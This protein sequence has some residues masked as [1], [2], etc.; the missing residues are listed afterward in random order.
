M[1]D[2]SVTVDRELCIG[3]GMCLVYAENTFAHDDQAKAVVLEGSSDPIDAIRV[4]VDACPVSALRL[5][6]DEQGA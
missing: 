2:R 3:S 5:V 1:S 6:T 4:A